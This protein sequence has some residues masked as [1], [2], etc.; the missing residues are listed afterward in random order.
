MAA[1]ERVAEEL[2]DHFRHEEV[3]MDDFNFGSLSSASG[4]P[5][6]AANSHAK[7]HARILDL[8]RHEVRR[9][10]K[11]TQK[12]GPGLGSGVVSPAVCRAV[13][14]AFEDHAEKFDVL[15][16]GSIPASAI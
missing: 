14:R 16:A 13:A 15:Y 8:A 10:Q 1:L 5:F 12:A 11:A 3:L 6:S 9:V 4:S 7:D 2:E